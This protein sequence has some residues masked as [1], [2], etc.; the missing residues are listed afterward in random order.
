MEEPEAALAEL[1]LVSI[2]DRD[3]WEL[4][5]G[6]VAQ[7][8]PGSGAFRQFAMSRHKVGMEVSLDDVP[9]FPIPGSRS[10]DVEINVALRIDDR[11]HAL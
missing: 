11:C 9:D 10:L 4:S 5:A 8:D 6:S 3:V 2:L 7:I 1:N